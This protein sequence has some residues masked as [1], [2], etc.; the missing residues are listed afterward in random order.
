MVTGCCLYVAKPT[1]SAVTYAMTSDA[2]RWHVSAS[3][4]TVADLW[5]EL[6]RYF[7][8]RVRNSRDAED[9][10]GTTWLAAGRTFQGRTTLRAYLYAIA[11]RLVVEYFRRIPRRPWIFLDREDPENLIDDDQGLEIEDRIDADR[12]DADRLRRALAKIPDPFR[13]VVEMVLQGYGHVEIAQVLGV[14]YNTIRSRY[15]RGKKH[16]LALLESDESEWPDDE[17]DAD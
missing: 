15:G 7:R 10:V 16:L 14:N 12:I 6:R 13:D 17:P 5:E 4:G 1:L 9:L 8:G 2:E 3:T 11:R